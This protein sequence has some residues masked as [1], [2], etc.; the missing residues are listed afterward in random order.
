MQRQAGRDR[1]ERRG[2]EGQKSA[3]GGEGGNC[4]MGGEKKN[5]YTVTPPFAMTGPF[6]ACKSDISNLEK[7]GAWRAE[8]RLCMRVRD[9]SRRDIYAV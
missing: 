1:K 5:L 7:R 6:T 9:S 4:F 2:L 8:L 3:W